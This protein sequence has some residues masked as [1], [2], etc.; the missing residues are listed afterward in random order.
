MT[1]APDHTR[2]PVGWSGLLAFGFLGLILIR[3]GIPTTPYFDEVH[4]LPAAR[5]M[6]DLSHI[7]NQE[8][9]LLGKE[10]LA[11][12]IMLFGDEPYGWRVFPA[13]AGGVTLFAFMRALW[14]ASL[15]RFTTLAGGLLLATD[16]LLFIHARIAMLDVFMVCFMMVALW[17]CAAAVREPET[18]RWRLPLAG[19]ALGFAMASKWNAIPVAMV[20]GLAFFAAR[21]ISEKSRVFTSH[22]GA[23][24]PGVTLAQAFLWLGV[25]PLLAYAITFLPVFFYEKDPLTIGS[26]LSYHQRMLDLQEMVTQPHP[27]QSQWWD[28]VL[29]RRAIWY[30]YENVDGAQRGVLLIGNPATML[31][32]LPAMLWCGYAGL[33]KR[34]WAALGVFALYAVSLGMWMIAPKPVQFYYHYFL[35][36]CFLIAGLALAMEDSW[37]DG[38]RWFP[39][40]VMAT[41]CGLFAYFFPIISAAPLADPQDF[42]YWAW[43]D[44]WR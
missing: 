13:L 11:L 7:T 2:D 1:K 35:P 15:A 31:L 21:L 17:M 23:P 18:G 28:W 24:V 40:A 33:F 5:V 42:L 36:S 30:L 32:G 29:N 20:P 22:R 9:P 44:S 27:Y 19:V 34:N 14:F 38:Q 8:H 4:Y 3:L 16:F 43:L 10:I 25:I 41:S 12:G 37:K 6:M 39:L 26:F